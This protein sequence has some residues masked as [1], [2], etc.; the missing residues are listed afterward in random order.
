M[1]KRVWVNQGDIVLVG[2]REFQDSKGDVI[3]KYT[4][5]EARQLKSMNELPDNGALKGFAVEMVVV[6]IWDAHAISENQRDW[7]NWF[8]RRRGMQL[9][10]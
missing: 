5:E 6:L 1:R 4:A 7:A 2:L 9:C 10:V 3:L 8:R